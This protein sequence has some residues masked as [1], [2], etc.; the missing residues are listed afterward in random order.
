MNSKGFTVLELAVVLIIVA[1]LA[2]ISISIF[3]GINGTARDGAAKYDLAEV[4]RISKLYYCDHEG[5]DIDFSELQEYGFRLSDG[6][7]LHIENGYEETF[8]ISASHTD[9]DDVYQV[10]HNGVITRR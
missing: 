8:L 10:D 2:V 3:S 1:I 5:T 7:V 4:Y 6:V 9:R